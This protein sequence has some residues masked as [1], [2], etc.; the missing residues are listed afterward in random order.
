MIFADGDQAVAA[1]VHPQ[2]S[3]ATL[4]FR[5]NRDGSFPVT[6]AINALIGVVAKVNVIATERIGAATVLMGAGTDV[7][8]LGC[9]GL[10]RT[11]GRL[12]H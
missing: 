11:I 3:V 7:E 9:H 5:G 4:S 10:Q 2:I 1:L 12:P 6:L 8:T